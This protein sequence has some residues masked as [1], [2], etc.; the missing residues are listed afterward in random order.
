MTDELKDVAGV[1]IVFESVTEDTKL[2][3]ALKP[4]RLVVT[5]LCITSGKPRPAA[6]RRSWCSR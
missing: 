1:E 4:L 6:P 2:M 3:A 5:K